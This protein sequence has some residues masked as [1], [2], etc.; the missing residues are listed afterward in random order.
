MA[1]TSSSGWIEGGAIDGDCPQGIVER[2]PMP[3]ADLHRVHPHA[4][5]I[6]LTVLT[7]RIASSATFALKA[8]V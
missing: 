2:D 7:P 1:A 5:L 4:C 6:P 8:A 3:R